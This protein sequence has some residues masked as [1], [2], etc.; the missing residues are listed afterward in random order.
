MILLSPCLWFVP[1]QRP[2]SSESGWF[3][4]RPSASRTSRTFRTSSHVS[5]CGVGRL[6]VPTP[7]SDLDRDLTALLNAATPLRT[8]ASA[9]L[10]PS[11][12]PQRPQGGALSMLSS[13]G[14]QPDG[15]GSAPPPPE[16]QREEGRHPAPPGSHNC[17]CFCTKIND[18]F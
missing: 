16:D 14:L 7:T 10:L 12:S 2:G 17:N 3:S 8:A 4:F 15:G 6:P 18:I 13:R 5:V 9:G 11:S 1:V